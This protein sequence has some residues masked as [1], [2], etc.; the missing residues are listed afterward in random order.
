MKYY[1]LLLALFICKN[2]HT[3]QND[4][5]IIQKDTLQEVI[6]QAFNYNKQWQEV[7]SSVAL[8]NTKQLQQIGNSSMLPALNT[9][10]GVR[11]EERS[12][13]SY[14]LSIR[15]SLLRSPFGVRN[16]KVYWN[17]IPLTDGGGNTYLNLVDVT[18]LS[19][20]EI[21]KGPAAS[22]YG[23]NTGGLVLL[24]SNN[25]FSSQPKNSYRAAVSGG[26]YGLFQ[27]N[28][29]WQYQNKNFSSQLIQS[30]QQSD[31]YRL[32]SALQKDNITWNG[33]FKFKQQQL[34]VLAFYTRLYY[35]TPGGITMAQMQQNP[36]AARITANGIPGSVEQKAAIYN[37][38][39]FAGLHH[40]YA[41]SSSFNTDVA[42]V[43][44]HTSFKNPFITNYEKRQ[45]DNIGMNGKLIY[46]QQ[47]NNVQLQWITGGE[48][49]GNHS[50]IDN[51]GNR[52]GEQDTVQYRDDIFTNQWFAFT[53][54]QLSHAKWNI[55]AGASTNNQHFRYKRLTDGSSNYT[56]KNTSNAIMPSVSALYKITSTASV[57][58]LASKGFSAPSLAE[59][60]PSDG[61]FY[62]NLN[63]EQGWNYEAG[64]KGTALK[65]QLEFDVNYYYF[66]LQ[67]T[68]VRR[69]NSAGAEYFI[70]AGNTKQEGLELWMQYHLLRRQHR[71]FKS[72]NISE[73]Y[74]YQPYYFTDYK[75]GSI[76]YSGKELTGVPRKTSVT[77]LTASLHNGIFLN[78]LFNYTAAIPLTDANDVYADDY[79][80]LQAKAGWDFKIGK[81]AV[82]VYAGGDNLL[83]QVYSLGNDINALGRRYYNPS[84]AINFYGGV[85]VKW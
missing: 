55:N 57:Y 69:T 80:L 16:I 3:Q 50:K 5:V 67:N 20:V 52:G 6:V 28:A 36:R 85:V 29:A 24:Q 12:P 25:T 19:S 82:Q 81:T 51:Y 4:S 45:E 77:T 8:L 43:Y 84:P 71:L 64:F 42:A 73:S 54:L 9:V 38:T 49:L 61:N 32:Q 63:P 76:D 72:I 65:K 31:G 34:D 23:A 10:A 26:S 27:Q 35:Q 68:I 13:G 2:A 33:S 59:V 60:R 47:L 22:M 79:R 15:G 11:M 44:S 53:Q 70:N 39:V 41:I 58:A 21:S 1:C 30:H 48:F 62:P 66:S 75:Q 40:N 83:N 18:Q 78:V 46:K 74:S 37:N 17:N 7:A 14:R 56:T